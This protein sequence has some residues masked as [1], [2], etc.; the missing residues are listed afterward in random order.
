MLSQCCVNVWYQAKLDVNDSL[1]L[2]VESRITIWYVSILFWAHFEFLTFNI[3][4]PIYMWVAVKYETWDLLPCT[5]TDTDSWNLLQEP[6]CA[7]ISLLGSHHYEIESLLELNRVPRYGGTS[8]NKFYALP[9]LVYFPVKFPYYW[10]LNL[11]FICCIRIVLKSLSGLTM[12]QNYQ[13][14]PLLYL[15]AAL[16]HSNNFSF[17]RYSGLN[18]LNF[19]NS[20]QYFRKKCLSAYFIENWGEM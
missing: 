17:V 19:G 18:G 14:V 12:N 15:M 16:M 8:P 10:T 7:V 5:D 11:G 3:N 2:L 4:M 20:S 6:A 13:A 1:E 9:S